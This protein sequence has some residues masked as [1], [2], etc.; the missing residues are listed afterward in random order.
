MASVSLARA[1]VHLASDLSQ[2]VDLWSADWSDVPGVRGDVRTY[3]N[4]RVR[5]VRRA[6]RTRELAI[7][8]PIVTEAELDF[9]ISLAGEV[10]LVRSKPGGGNRGRKVYCTWF[11]VPTTDRKDGTYIA[12]VKATEVSFTEA[13]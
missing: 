3:A 2:S 8:F 7:T 11:E 13:V 12:K 5:I 10:A 1:W 9:L 6:G 4:G